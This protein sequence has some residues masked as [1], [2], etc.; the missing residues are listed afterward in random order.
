MQDG[1]SKTDD[2]DAYSIFDLLLQ[3]KFFLPVARDAA[4]KAAYRLLR[5]HMA[6]KKRV[7]QLRHQL[8]AAIHLAFPA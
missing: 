7:R 1:T 8:R 3:G 2:K 6:L 4:L 5:R